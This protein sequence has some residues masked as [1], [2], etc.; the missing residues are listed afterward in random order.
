MRQLLALVAIATGLALGTGSHPAAACSCM[1]MDA[2][3]RLAEADVVFT[4]TFDETNPDGDQRIAHR[5]TVDRVYKGDTSVT[6]VV[7]SADDTAACGT[8]FVAAR[9]LVYAHRPAGSDGLTT[10]LCSGNIRLTGDSGLPEGL[11]AGAEPDADPPHEDTPDDDGDEPADDRP[12][13][14]EAD[15][16]PADGTEIDGTAIDTDTPA[17]A[18]DGAGWRGIRPL[19]V[20]LAGAVA[21]VAILAV[22]LLRLRR[23]R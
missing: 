14:A 12:A 18:T 11:G 19:P 22:S 16:T 6:T 9:F 7:T 13:D 23:H 20:A 17:Q 4:G 15:G 3:T 21:A 2:A 8:E 10:G 1:E 5:F